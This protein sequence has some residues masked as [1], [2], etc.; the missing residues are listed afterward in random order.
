MRRLL[1]CPLL[2]AGFMAGCST[3]AAGGRDSGHNA[4]AGGDEFVT[5]EV[6]GR[7]WV[8]RKGTEAFADYEKNGEPGKCATM[9]GVGPGGKTIKSDSTATIISYLSAKPGFHTEVVDGRLWVLEKN[10]EAYAEFKANG[11]PAK[12]ITMIGVGP[13][14]MSVRSDSQETYVKYRSA[15][16]GFDVRLAEGRIWVFKIG[17]AG[18]ADFLAHGEPGKN[19]TII[20]GGPDGLTVKSDSLETIQEWQIA[21]P[22]FN[23]Y[24]REGRIWV[25]KPGSEDEQEFLSVGEPAKNVT[26]IGAGPDGRTVKSADMAVIEAYLFAVRG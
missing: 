23:T 13:E 26:A 16:P 18:H 10:S 2:L 11:E 7:I 12:S 22:G 1:L 14:G 25:F 5:E 21:A 17:S 9:I 6:D 19:A 4:M 20:G 8:F 24:L 15:K 3:T